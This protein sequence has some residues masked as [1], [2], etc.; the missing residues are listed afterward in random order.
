VPPEVLGIAQGGWHAWPSTSPPAQ[1]QTHTQPERVGQGAGRGALSTGPGM[2]LARRRR[3]DRD[4]EGHPPAP[5]EGGREPV[6][7]PPAGSS[8]LSPA[9]KPGA[10]GVAQPSDI[11]TNL[12]DSL[13]SAKHNQYYGYR[14]ISGGEHPIN[15]STSEDVGRFKLFGVQ[16]YGRL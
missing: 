13:A 12:Q 11:Y 1:R 9:Q 10:E 14:I 7:E 3:G 6:A 8:G 5:A 16:V 2:E 15:T 4:P